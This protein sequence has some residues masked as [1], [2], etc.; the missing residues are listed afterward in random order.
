MG[1]IENALL[2]AKAQGL[3]VP[4][5]ELLGGKIRD[6]I[7]VYWSH[8]ATWRI[9]HPDVTS[10]RSPTSKA[11]RRSAARCARK[12]YRA[13]DEHLHLHK[14]EKPQGWR[15]GFGAPFEPGLNVERN[16]LRDLVM[17]LEAYA[18]AP[19]RTSTSCS[20]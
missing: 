5:Y 13:E 19:G 8:C 16:M 3:G 20:T 11:S 6:R 14:D 2:D 18:K 7:R 9:N 17:H 4:G 12:V 10:R 15:P 1:A